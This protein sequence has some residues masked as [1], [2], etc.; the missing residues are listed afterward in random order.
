MELFLKSVAAIEQ[1]IATDRIARIEP[2]D[3]QAL[4]E[5]DAEGTPMYQQH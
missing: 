2:K 5:A 4:V 1:S 3:E